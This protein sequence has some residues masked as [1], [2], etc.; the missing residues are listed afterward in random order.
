MERERDRKIQSWIDRY[1]QSLLSWCP[2]TSRIE[3]LGLE[4]I[5]CE[6]CDWPGPLAADLLPR[7]VL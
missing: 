7:S 1:S 3:R 5:M 2:P 4:R 6:R